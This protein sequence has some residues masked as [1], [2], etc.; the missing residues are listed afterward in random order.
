VS[1]KKDGERIIGKK[2]RE[3]VRRVRS[4]RVRNMERWDM[5]K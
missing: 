1:K 2:V 3:K 4:K 5:D